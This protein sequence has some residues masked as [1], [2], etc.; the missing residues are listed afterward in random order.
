[1]KQVIL[2]VL[3]ALVVLPFGGDLYAKLPEINE[4]DVTEIFQNIMDGHVTHKRLT[5]V[6]VKRIL[7]NFLEELD[8]SKTYFVENEI[9]H[10][11]NPSPQTLENIV[12]SYYKHRFQRVF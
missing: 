7:I 12:Y 3:I 8:P 11:S 2:K 4:K 10:W 9:Q 6:L 1:M 5:P